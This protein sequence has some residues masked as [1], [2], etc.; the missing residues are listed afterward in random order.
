MNSFIRGDGGSRTH[1]R[2]LKRRLLCL[3]ATSPWPSLL[4]FSKC[5]RR[6]GAHARNR[7]W[8]TALRGRCSTVERGRDLRSVGTTEGRIPCFGIRPS[9]WRALCAV[10]SCG[11]TPEEGSDWDACRRWGARHVLR[12]RSVRRLARSSGASLFAKCG[13]SD[14]PAGPT[15]AFVQDQTRGLG[16]G[17]TIFRG[18]RKNYGVIVPAAGCESAI[19]SRISNESTRSTAIAASIRSRSPRLCRPAT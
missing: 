10:T 14:P 6:T 18:P 4:R 5:A 12:N 3:R 19:K 17:F 1:T 9:P 11:R 8:A 15:R 16:I 13:A 2:A 7:T